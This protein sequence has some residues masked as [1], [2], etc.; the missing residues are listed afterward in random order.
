MDI[1]E[2]FSKLGELLSY[3][4]YDKVASVCERLISTGYKEKEIHLV[5]FLAE[6]KVKDINDLPD[7]EEELDKLKSYNTIITEFDDDMVSYVRECNDYIHSRKMDELDSLTKEDSVSETEEKSNFDGLFESEDDEKDEFAPVGRIGDEFS[8]DDSFGG[9]DD[10][11]YSDDKYSDDKYSDDNYS[12]D[13]YSDDRYSDDNYSDDNYSE[14]GYRYSSN[15]DSF[16]LEDDRFGGRNSRYETIGTDEFGDEERYDNRRNNQYGGFQDDEEDDDFGFERKSKKKKSKRKDSFVDLY[17]EQNGGYS[18][19]YDDDNEFD[20]LD[21]EG[22]AIDFVLF[23]I[24]VVLGVAD[25]ASLAF[26]M[27]SGVF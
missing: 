13:K 10:D 24:A 1:N 21:E 12:D 22:P 3:G 27:I 17:E 4:E 19:R 5:K 8:A 23:I 16:S 20:D 2:I 26:A 14:A 7:S 9:A 11:K 6:A 15:K 25:I 18:D